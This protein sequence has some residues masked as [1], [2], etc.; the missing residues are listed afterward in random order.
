M[1]KD[2]KPLYR[3]VNATAHNV[4]HYKGSDAKYYRNKKSGIKKSMKKDVQRG[5]DYT[6]LYKFLLSKVDEDWTNVH[7]EAIKRL[8]CEEP[9]FHLVAKDDSEKR[10]YVRCGESS[11][12]SG[13][14]VDENNKL[15]KVNPNFKNEDLTP[16]CDCCTHTFN[17]KVLIK[18]YNYKH[19]LG[20]LN[21]KNF[22]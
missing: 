4:D 10:D 7:S 15:K 1:N 19:Y 9:I 11:Y 17:G 6:P 5:L 3:K 16:S 22:V 14:Y 21:S 8:D 18:K 13:L 20:D 12:Y 2:I